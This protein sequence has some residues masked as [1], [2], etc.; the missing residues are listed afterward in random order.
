[1]TLRREAIPWGA[2]RPCFHY[3]AP[4]TGRYVGAIWRFGD[5]WQAFS[6]VAGAYGPLGAF[7]SESEAAAA[8]AE[9][10]GGDEVEVNRPVRTLFSTEIQCHAGTVRSI[11]RR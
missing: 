4:D 9:R 11:S 5:G 1:M 10:V 3:F 2:N 8:L 7:A 6:T